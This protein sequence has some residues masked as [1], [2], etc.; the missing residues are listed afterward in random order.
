[1]RILFTF[2]VL[3]PA[4][5]PVAAFADTD[6][7]R[8]ALGRTEK[9]RILV[10]K[11]M[12]P[13]AKWI[14]EDWMIKEAAEAGFNVFSPRVGYDRLDE[15]RRV[16]GWCGQYHIFYMP[17]MRGS[18]TAPDTADADGKRVVWE[19]G[20]EQPLWS[21]NADAFWEW[22]N[23]YILEYARISVEY[24]ALMGVFLDYE[25]YAP[26]KQGNLYALSY[27]E[28]ILGRFADARSLEI[29][30]LP[31]EKRKAWLETQGL[32][33]AFE[34]FQVNHWRER[35]R[36]LRQEVD[37]IAPDFQFCVYPAPG[38]PFMVRAVYPEWAT[39]RAPLILADA[40]TYG[41]PSRF[42]SE[43]ESL[44][45]NRA[46]MEDGIKV[47]R[48]AGIPFMYTG[49]IDPV[50]R[51]ADPEF[52]GKNAVMIS[53][54]TDGYW[55]FYKGPTYTKE[56]HAAYWKWFAWANKAIME[57]R[58]DAQHQPRETPDN[59]FASLF[60]QVK[61]GVIPVAVQGTGEA[62]EL[63]GVKLRGDN[64]IV[65]SVAAGRPLDVL[66]RDVPVGRYE[67]LLHWELR[68][69]SMKALLSGTIP[70]GE[71]GSVTFT[72]ETNGLLFLVLSSGSCAYS[73]VKTNVPVGLYAAEGLSLIGG[74]ERLY[75]CVPDGTD[76][77]SITIKGQGAETARLNLY[78]PAGSQVAT[79]QT[80]R[81]Q[82]NAKATVTLDKES[83][84]GIYA[85]EITRADEGV[86]E[87]CTVALD[88]VLPPTL[89]LIPEQVF[90]L[91][92]EK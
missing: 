78:D 22:T 54:V 52:S 53:E 8:A 32:Y 91:V 9:L 69:A 40:S 42:Q 15:V 30:A 24:P 62:R 19:N 27:D 16:A 61:A 45:G 57:G 47:P 59:W 29:P 46:R 6:P 85:L 48:E 33:E 28:D 60:S 14:T 38:T 26:G 50:V 23:R 31:M 18:L 1:M 88:P 35:C 74:V 67:D 10:D 51:G 3:I 34:Q 82:Q 20:A 55:I 44:E 75:F 7:A 12:Q 64:L 81:K 76:A 5:I 72:P 77:F 68:D 49:G 56:D 79:A 63:P 73:I 17:W 43:A 25:N 89:S 66:L 37:A 41:R 87:D 80:S 39:A 83:G 2:V 71:S 84:D 86:L 65:L 36:A 4:L 92:T 13:E 90:Q 11:V 21:P 70:H 58:F